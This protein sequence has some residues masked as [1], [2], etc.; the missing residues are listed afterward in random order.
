MANYNSNMLCSNSL[1]SAGE[2]EAEE[3]FSRRGFVSHGV[4]SWDQI[5]PQK[6]THQ[7]DRICSALL[8]CSM[9]SALSLSVCV[10]HT[11]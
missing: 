10:M 1:S 6:T 7:I 9:A 4:C 2:D 3:G 8:N 11:F 5:S